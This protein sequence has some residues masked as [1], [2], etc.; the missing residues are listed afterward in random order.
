M[1]PQPQNSRDIAGRSKH[2][3]KAQLK[4]QQ[5]LRELSTPHWSDLPEVDFQADVQEDLK[6]I[7][8][9]AA[10][11][12]LADQNGNSVVSQLDTWNYGRG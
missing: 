3:T 11:R 4:R 5:R 9:L 8:L 1:L 7:A 12:Q 6:T 2:L 10:V